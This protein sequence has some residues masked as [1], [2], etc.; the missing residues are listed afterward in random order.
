MRLD[1]YGSQIQSADQDELYNLCSLEAMSFNFSL[2]IDFFYFQFLCDAKQQTQNILSNKLLITCMEQQW[3]QNF[4]E[5]KLP[6]FTFVYVIMMFIGANSAFRIK[7]IF[8]RFQIPNIV[9]SDRWKVYSSTFIIGLSIAVDKNKGLVISGFIHFCSPY[10]ILRS[11]F[12]CFC[13]L[14]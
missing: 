11:I 12:C 6:A 13:S 9:S 2:S 7:R 14:Q 1:F 4:S 3:A 5:L 10:V 8:K